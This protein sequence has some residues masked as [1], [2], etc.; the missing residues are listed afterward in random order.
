MQGDDLDYELL[1]KLDELNSTNQ[2]DLAV[3]MGIS[4][5][6]VNFCLRAVIE[7]GW[8][9][10]NNFKRADNKWAYAY[11]LTPNGVSAKVSLAKAFLERK[12]RE[13]EQLQAEIDRLRTE[14]ESEQK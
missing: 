5:G 4:V 2:R 14:I 8:V 12:E 10:V 9:K 6:K 11:L 13:F 7:K 3:R 1:R